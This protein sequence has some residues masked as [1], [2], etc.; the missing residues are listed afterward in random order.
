MAKSNNTF[1]C[2]LIMQLT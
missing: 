1:T 2:C